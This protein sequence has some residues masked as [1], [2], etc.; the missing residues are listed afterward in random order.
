LEREQF[1][2]GD[3]VEV[4]NWCEEWNGLA[5]VT[6][7]YNEG[8]WVCVDIPIVGATWASS[9]GCSGGFPVK[10]IRLVMKHTEVDTNANTISQ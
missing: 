3:W 8:E 5:I 2:V 6:H 9:R 1:E 4:I 7:V 10:H